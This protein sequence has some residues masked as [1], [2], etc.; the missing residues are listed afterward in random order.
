MLLFCLANQLI[1][2]PALSLVILITHRAI[3]KMA[4]MAIL[5]L[6]ATNVMANGNIIMAIRGI[7]VKEHEKTSS[8]MLDSYQSDLLFRRFK[9]FFDFVIFTALFTM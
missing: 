9:Y 3:T 1:P 5:A 7:P 6:M 4:K 8:V 2:C